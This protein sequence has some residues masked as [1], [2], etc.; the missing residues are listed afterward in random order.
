MEASFPL[1]VFTQQMQVASRVSRVLAQRSSSGKAV[2]VCLPRVQARSLVVRVQV[3]PDL[4][5]TDPVATT[6]TTE[7]DRLLKDL[8]EKWDRVDNKGQV[9]LYTGGAVFALFLT[10]TVLGAI[11]NVPLLPKLLELVGLAYS[12]WFT[13]RYLLFKANREELMKEVQDLKGKIQS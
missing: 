4:K 2:P 13:Y 5:T 3:E 7:A 12:A 6:E 11:N 1:V 9:A 8:S 10:N